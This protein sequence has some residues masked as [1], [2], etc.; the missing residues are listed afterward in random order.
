MLT[1]YTTIPKFIMS[2]K[3]AMSSDD[4]NESFKISNQTLQKDQ[5]SSSDQTGSLE[6]STDKN[7]L[8]DKEQQPLKNKKPSPQRSIF[9][10]MAG[11]NH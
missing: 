5:I 7:L 2:E 8:S 9:V 10:K 1:T 11:H 3:R 6:F 4:S